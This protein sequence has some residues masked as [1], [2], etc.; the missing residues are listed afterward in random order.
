MNLQKLIQ[1]HF[2]VFLMFRDQN[3]ISSNYILLSIS[4]PGRY[5][6]VEKNYETRHGS[7][8]LEIPRR[9]NL[10]NR[11][12]FRRFFVFRRKSCNSSCHF[13]FWV[14]FNVTWKP[15][16]CYGFWSARMIFISEIH[17]DFCRGN[18]W[19]YQ[20]SNVIFSTFLGEEDRT[21]KLSTVIVR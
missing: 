3:F 2:L 16:W 9:W 6:L 19:K 21:I 10:S 8:N 20:F 14:F 11:L 4:F 1:I 5:L 18:S 15:R 13:R 12:V 7:V 17:R